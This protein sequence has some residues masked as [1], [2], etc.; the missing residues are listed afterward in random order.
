MTRLCRDRVK[1]PKPCQ[2]AIRTE[3]RDLISCDGE[4]LSIRELGAYKHG[5]M[6]HCNCSTIIPL[7]YAHEIM[8]NRGKSLDSEIFSIADLRAKASEKLPRVFKGS[9]LY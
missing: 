9:S 7:S 4:P 1:G 3:S 8:A 2:D 6:D 5:S